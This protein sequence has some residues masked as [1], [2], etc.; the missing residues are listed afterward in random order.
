MRQGGMPSVRSGVSPGVSLPCLFGLGSHIS[1]GA[2]L[3]QHTCYSCSRSNMSVEVASAGSGPWHLQA[4]C[5]GHVVTCC[6]GSSS[7]WLTVPHILTTGLWLPLPG[8]E[9]DLGSWRGISLSSHVSAGSTL[10]SKEPAGCS[11]ALP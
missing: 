10:P 3:R 8:A 4:G 5:C 6:S 11:C 1:M 2:A 9:P 7:T